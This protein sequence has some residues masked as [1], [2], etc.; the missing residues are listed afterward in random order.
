M[1]VAV[2]VAVAVAGAGA[3]VAVARARA[4]AECEAVGTRPL[5]MD[6]VWG[7]QEASALKIFKALGNAREA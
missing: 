3:V 1:A 4:R 6:L 2:A 5:G 7:G